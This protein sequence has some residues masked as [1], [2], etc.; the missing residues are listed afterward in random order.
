MYKHQQEITWLSPY[1][2]A[3]GTLYELIVDDEFMRA[4]LSGMVL[5]LPREMDSKLRPF[6]GTRIGILRTDLPGEE[7]LVRSLTSA[8]QWERSEVAHRSWTEASGHEE[9][10]V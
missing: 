9:V 3:D 1:E 6:L 5:V 10:R 2:E 8:M 4:R 7:Y